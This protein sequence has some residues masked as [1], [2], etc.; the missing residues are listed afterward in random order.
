MVGVFDVEHS[1]Q[2]FAETGLISAVDR[3]IH[4]D[5]HSFAQSS[6]RPDIAHASLTFI[7]NSNT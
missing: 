7:R 5:P 6:F 4:S 1:P 3:I 2:E